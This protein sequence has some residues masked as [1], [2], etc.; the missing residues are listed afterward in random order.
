MPGCTDDCYLYEEEHSILFA[1]NAEQVEIEK[2]LKNLEEGKSFDP[3]VLNY[4]VKRTCLG[5]FI[6]EEDELREECKSYR[7]IPGDL[8]VPERINIFN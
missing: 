7:Y 6:K 1:N 2:E 4:V 3:S 5:N 8:T